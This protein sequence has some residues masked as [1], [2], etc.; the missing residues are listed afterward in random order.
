MSRKTMR[1]ASMTAL[2]V[3]VGWGVG[4]WAQTPAPAEAQ[5]LPPQ[6]PGSRVDQV[7]VDVVVLDAKGN[8]VPGLQKGDFTV[9]E[10]GQPKSITNF[11]FIDRRSGA[12]SA[13]VPR[14]RPRVATNQVPVADRL[15]SGRNFVLLF[16]DLSLMPVNAHQAK[17]AVAAFLDKGVVEGDQVT[18]IA[19]S[20]ATWWST[21]MK[22]GRED[23]M[24]ILKR[25]D[26]RRIPETATERV[27]DYEALQIVYFHDTSVA[28]RVQDRMERYGS[29]LVQEHDKAAAASA[30]ELFQRG[31]VDPYVESL[32]QET[33][34]KMRTRVEASLQVI[35]R[36]I[37]SL[38]EG[39]DRKAL[40]LVSEGFVYDP[41]LP[42][43]KR[44]IEAARRVNATL[45]YIDVTGLRALDPMYSAE[46]GPALD[47]RD[48]MTAIA[49]LRNEGEGSVALAADTG[50]FSIRG[51]NDFKTGAARI[52]EESQAFYLLGYDPGEVPK[53][54]KFRKIEV[55]VRG[56]YTVRARR[57][58]YAEDSDGTASHSREGGPDPVLQAALDAPAVSGEIP[59]RMT[60]YVMEDEVAG[61][62]KVVVAAD[63]D[64][65]HVDFK[66][67]EGQP[68]ATLDTILVVAH[69]DSGDSERVDQ[70]VEIQRKAG[71][72]PMGPAWYSFVREVVIPTG[73]YQAKLVVRDAASKRVGTVA[74][75]FGVPSRDQLRVST[76]VLT[77]T[78]ASST[79][80]PVPAIIAR[81]TFSPSAQLYC[82][83]DVYG[84][85]KGPDGLPKV[86]AAHA[87]RRSDGSLVGRAAPTVIEPTSLGA[88]ARMVQIPLAGIPV[89]DY[90]L[91]LSVKDQV[92]GTT[93]ELVEPFSIV[94]PGTK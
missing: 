87:V 37:K 41:S 89:G 26:G 60:A 66:D 80:G 24:A 63:A 17:T 73:E 8:P 32:A 25:L 54:G 19:T 39:R 83:F 42:G 38:A 47:T 56:R 9:R 78:L 59:L 61:K 76:P 79:G 35:E 72:L 69:R 3:L 85:G 84:A 88:L 16:D 90:E 92:T 62:V 28:K 5:S 67:V 94:A 49:D 48:T 93:R 57:G 14:A 21:R 45:Y 50:G 55:K 18:L 27:T 36:S 44:V 74:Y 91:V 64:I 20:G 13:E 15:R 82:R 75:E 30:Q 2:A 7:T 40:I 58:Y 86:E 68:R 34:L 11:E 10:E 43:L 81:R 51:S 12:P 1:A 70:L 77:D 6:I 65:S 52:G 31:V 23:I 4:A 22:G 29:K 46:F 33:Y 53:D 71:A